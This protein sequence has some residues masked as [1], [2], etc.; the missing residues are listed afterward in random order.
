M[1]DLTTYWIMA[2]VVS[3]IFL[4]SGSVAEFH[5]DRLAPGPGGIPGITM[6]EM[7]SSGSFLD[8]WYL[9][10]DPLLGVVEYRD[11]FADG[12]QALYAPG[13]YGRWGGASMNIGDVLSYQ[14]HQSNVSGAQGWGWQ[15]VKLTAL[16]PEFSVPAGTFTDVVQIDWT[17]SWC[18][19]PTCTTQT[20]FAGTYWLAQGLGQ[21][22]MRWAS[23]PGIVSL[24]AYTVTPK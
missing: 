7:D 15:T 24:G 2:Q 4:S 19:N 20:A 18:A 22:Q 10:V 17:Q 9:A 6:K 1:V 14:L 11:D 16:I 21:I 8:T 5:Q 12:H 23:S 3:K 13:Y